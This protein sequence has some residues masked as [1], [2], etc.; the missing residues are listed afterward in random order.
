MQITEPVTMLTDYAL[1]AASLAFALFTAGLIG[2]RN[3]VSAWFWCAAFVA[4]AVAAAFGGT[5]HGFSIYL[6]T[7]IR[8]RLWNIAL[9]STG[10]AAAFFTAGIHSAYIKRRDGTVKWLVWGIVVT[11]FGVTVQ[12]SG[13][14]RHQNFNHNDAYHIIQ[15]VALYFLYCC[16]RTLRDRPG[17]PT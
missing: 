10:A 7:G 4:S 6:A 14:P 2:P 17:I 12:Q 16:G 5:Y 9:Y 1:A 8:G 3:R 11:L 13:L 15:I